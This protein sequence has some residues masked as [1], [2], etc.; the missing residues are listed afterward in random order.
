V[1]GDEV[2]IA[3]MNVFGVY[4]GEVPLNSSNLIIE[5]RHSEVTIAFNDIPMPD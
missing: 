2:M 4:T 3:L 1:A 5:V